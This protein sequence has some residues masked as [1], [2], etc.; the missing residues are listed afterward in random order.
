MRALEPEVFD[1]VWA[2]IEAL[3]PVHA[4]IHPLGCHRPRVSD[5][6]ASR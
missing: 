6:D 5:R 2:A 1:T 3:L 4:E